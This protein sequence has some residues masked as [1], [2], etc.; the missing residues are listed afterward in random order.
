MPRGKQ[1][2]QLKRDFNAASQMRKKQASN[3]AAKKGHSKYLIFQN[4]IPNV[5]YLSF[6]RQ[7]YKIDIKHF[8]ENN[9]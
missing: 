7:A 3:L 1:F 5:F 4:S 2:A 8:L 9:N 6:Q